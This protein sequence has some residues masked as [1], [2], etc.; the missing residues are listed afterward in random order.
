MPDC[1][2]CSLFQLESEGGAC[3][4][5]NRPG[6]LE[7][8]RQA[9]DLCELPASSCVLDVASGASSTLQ[10][11]GKEKGFQA[12]GLDLS[13][14]MLRFGQNR[15]PDLRLIQG[16]CS[17]IPLPSASQHAVLMECALTLS[18]GAD[19]ALSEFF[20]I[21]RPGG[22][23]IVTDV[24]VREVLDP[25]GLD[26]LSA[27][28]CLS[29]TATEETIRQ[30]V[31]KNG[32]KISVWQDHTLLFKQWLARMV[33]TLGSLETFYRQLMPCEGNV[34]SLATGLGKQVKLGYYLMIAQKQAE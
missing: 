29:G 15:H 33:F 6:G 23:L 12:A 10:F 5:V 18:G 8:T 30:Q 28:R 2:T 9:I 13:F 19:S 16:N 1:V 4:H 31:T 14:D 22:K 11:L 21:L 32:F 20:R 27:T 3:L 34:Q 17:Y 25:Q 7:L 24:Y 26:C